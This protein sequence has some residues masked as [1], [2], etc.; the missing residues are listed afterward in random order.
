MSPLAPAVTL[1]VPSLLLYLWRGRFPSRVAYALSLAGP[2]AALLIALALSVQGSPDLSWRWDPAAV[3]AQQPRLAA[4]PV[5]LAFIFTLSFVALAA[6]GSRPATDEP[7]LWTDLLVLAATAFFLTAANPTALLLAWFLLDASLFLSTTAWLGLGPAIRL[8]GTNLLGGTAWILFTSISIQTGG[9]PALS[10]GLAGIALWVRSG[11][12]PAQSWVEVSGALPVWRR[13]WWESVNLA[14]AGYLWSLAAGPAWGLGWLGLLV[15]LRGLLDLW[16]GP[17]SIKFVQVQLGLGAALAW[18]GSGISGPVI[19]LYFLSLLAAG[20]ILHLSQDLLATGRRWAP[21]LA[22]GLPTAIA[23]ASLAGTP[24]TLGFA[25]RW[26]LYH[27][28][29][30][31]PPPIFAMATLIFLL[32]LP[33][34]AVAL[35]EKRSLGISD[36]VGGW[37]WPWW[38]ALPTALLALTPFVLVRG[39]F[40]AG[41]LWDSALAGGAKGYSLWVMLLVPAA[42]AGLLLLRWSELASFVQ[43]LEERIAPGSR[44]ARIRWFLGAIG[45]AAG[46]ILE[47]VAWLGRGRHGAIW[48]TLYALGIALLTFLM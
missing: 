17:S 41:E 47:A 30:D 25:A 18:A 6:L 20:A 43:D 21:L 46:E 42:G 44:G 11:L 23:A 38:L 4:Q 22:T 31:A 3:P 24:P 35:R 36:E 7:S 10:A 5:S 26:L 19:A 27:E 9:D 37:I 15:S 48:L 34:L 39:G 12:Y 8:A 45:R 1:A 29:R 33:P 40:P 32:S 16:R 28:L 2:A 13:V 14:A